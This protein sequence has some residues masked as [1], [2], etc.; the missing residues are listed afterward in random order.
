MPRKQLKFN[1][2]GLNRTSESRWFPKEYSNDRENYK[3]LV[4]E[5][6]KLIEKYNT[7][8]DETNLR[9]TF[10]Q[11]V[12]EVSP[13][14]PNYKSKRGINIAL[15]MSDGKLKENATIA[16]NKIINILNL[17]IEI[18]DERIGSFFK[19]IATITKDLVT[20]FQANEDISKVKN[21]VENKAQVGLDSELAS[22]IA[23][24]LQATKDEESI[25]MFGSFIIIKKYGSDGKIKNITKTLTTEEQLI[26]ATNQDIL[27]SP[28]SFMESLE[29]K[30]KEY[31]MK[32]I[33]DNKLLER[34]I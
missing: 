25:F 34:N 10:I 5:Y 28:S 20:Q 7:L 31:N 4:K 18:E 14:P 32:L 27:K 21:Y 6:D 3:V 15:Y 8:V 29:Y 33:K 9:D 22:A 13:Y 12:Y 17:Q 16:I 1:N 11:S 24:L 2:I 26:I 30:V 23:Q 19:R